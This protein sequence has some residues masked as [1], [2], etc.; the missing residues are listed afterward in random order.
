MNS[1]TVL[2]VV[3]GAAVIAGLVSIIAS[4][5]STPTTT[6]VLFGGPS[7]ERDTIVAQEARRAGAPATLMLA[8]SHTENWSGDSTAT[9]VTGAKGLMQV[10]PNIWSDS[11]RVECGPAELIDRRRNACVGSRIYLQYF[12]ECGNAECA[13]RKYVGAWCTKRDSPERCAAKQRAGTAYVL[14]VVQK[15]GRTDLSPARDE[16]AFG[17]YRRD[18]LTQ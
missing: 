8:V 7:E 5:E 15:Y 11:F 1:G 9:S 12:A 18:S 10:M 14:A 4:A 3:V 6:P 17:K 16:M 2:R 13:L